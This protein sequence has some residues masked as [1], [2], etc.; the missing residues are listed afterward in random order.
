MTARGAETTRDAIRKIVLAL[1]VLS[2]PA[3]QEE[4]R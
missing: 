4:M 3:G 1:T 2:A